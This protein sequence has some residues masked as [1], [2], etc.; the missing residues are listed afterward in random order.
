MSKL[1]SLN[2]RPDPRTL[3]QFGFIALFGFGLL[4][5]LAYYEKAVFAFGLGDARLPVAYALGGL[6]A[7]SVLFSLVAPKANLPIYL[8]LT[9]ISLPI[10]FVLSYVIMGLLFF[11][12]FGVVAVILRL[13]GRDSMKRS[14]DR[15]A[16]T[17]WVKPP[18]PTTSDRYFSQ[19]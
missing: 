3:R 18:P 11:V 1:I 10:G 12:V 15:Q 7:L 16:E 8:G 9:V 19:Y 5:V 14:Y 13:I 17:Y 4:A 2:L 6:A